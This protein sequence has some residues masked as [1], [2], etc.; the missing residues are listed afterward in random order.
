[1][2]NKIIKTF[3]FLILTLSSLSIAEQIIISDEGFYKNITHEMFFTNESNKDFSINEVLNFA[4]HQWHDNAKK[5]PHLSKLS[6][7]NKIIWTKIKINNHLNYPQRIMLS[8]AFPFMDSTSFYVIRKNDPNAIDKPYHPNDWHASDSLF[9]QYSL[10]FNDRRISSN[11]HIFD[12]NINQGE[13]LWLYM[14]LK[15]SNGLGYDFYLGDA[16]TTIYKQNLYSVAD[17]FNI[18]F[19]ILIA[20]YSALIIVATKNKS[21]F[22]NII[23]ALS[24]IL[25]KLTTEGMFYNFLPD[26]LSF[27]FFLSSKFV[28]I[29]IALT[30]I[31][32]TTTAQRYFK[33]AKHHKKINNYFNINK[34]IILILLIIGLLISNTELCLNLQILIG[35]HWALSWLVTSIYLLYNF[36]KVEKDKINYFFLTW[37]ISILGATFYFITI[38]DLFINSIFSIK[39]LHL[40]FSFTTLTPVIIFG[41][42][43]KRLNKKIS[44][45]RKKLYFHQNNLKKLIEEGLAQA[46]AENR[47]LVHKQKILTQNINYASN[48]Q[49]NILSDNN[50]LSKLTEDYFMIFRPKDSCG[51]DYIWTQQTANAT[52]W[53]ALVDCTGH[54]APGAFMTIASAIN[55]KKI[56]NENS[57]QSCGYILALLNKHLK[58]IL[59]QQNKD[60][61]SNHGLDMALC[62]IQGTTLNYSGAKTPLY[63]IY[64]ENLKIIQPTRKSIGY[65]QTPNHM[66]FQDNSIALQGNERFYLTSDGYIDQCGGEKTLPFGRKRFAKAI[67]EGTPNK[68]FKEQKEYFEKIFSEY[69]GNEPQQDDLSFIGFKFSSNLKL[70]LF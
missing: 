15:N 54:G 17:F 62:K 59:H 40:C 25:F 58:S 11:W 27:D 1:M 55:L 60:A 26:F 53:I 12:F 29:S 52:R 67:L 16:K 6:K 35:F 51:G 36:Q 14:K 31:T 5:H 49:K 9:S 18:G 13:S 64:D 20:F 21:F 68:S 24:L 57:H 39:T 30:V 50:Q 45:D 8:N 28:S 37:I 56:I 32:L 66:I 19:L 42:R 61:V 70:D 47:L 3:I 38:D 23:L 34:I 10:K 22:I 41:I 69:K 65:R 43:A 7:R 2:G 44:K 48:I 63:M 4:E 46:I 33:L